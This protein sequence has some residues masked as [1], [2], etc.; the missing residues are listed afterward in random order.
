M[1]N[2]NKHRV[3]RREHKS[4]IRWVRTSLERNIITNGVRFIGQEL[5]TWTKETSLK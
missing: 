3:D 1:S 4:K 2:E 5:R